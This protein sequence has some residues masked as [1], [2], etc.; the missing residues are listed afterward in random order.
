MLRDK[1]YTYFNFFV[2]QL[3]NNLTYS[4]ICNQPCMQD[5]YAAAFCIITTV[6]SITINCIG[7]DVIPGVYDVLNYGAMG[8]GTTDDTLAFIKAWI[9][10]CNSTAT[11]P[12]MLIPAGKIYFVYPMNF[13]GPCR[14]IATYA[15]LSVVIVAPN[16]PDGWKGADLLA[17]RG[18]NG[19]TLNGSG[20]IDGRGKSWWDVSCR[21]HPEFKGCIGRAPTALMFQ[22][23]KEVYMDHFNVVNTPQ[24]HILVWGSEGVYF[25]FIKTDSPGTSPNTDGIHIQDSQH[26]E[27][28]GAE[29]K[30]GDDCVSIGDY[31]SHIYITDESCGP[32]HGIRCNFVQ[33]EEGGNLHPQ[34]HYDT[35]LNPNVERKIMFETN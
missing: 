22:G 13:T 26:V 3:E 21:H 15:T 7:A 10:T 31:C 14:S 34:Y 24:T 4:V 27:I 33:E 30:S 12:T 11:V 1:F 29:L 16:T 20:L 6:V 5:N 35:F 8:D 9:D 18:V 17:F 25:S 32:G 28:H 23:C 2:E 19:L